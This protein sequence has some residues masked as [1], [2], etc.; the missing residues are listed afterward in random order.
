MNYGNAGM[1]IRKATLFCHILVMMTILMMVNPDICA[2][3]VLQAETI[4][5]ETRQVSI[6]TIFAKEQ[7]QTRIR[8][9]YSPEWEVTPFMTFPIGGIVEIFPL[10]MG[11]STTISSVFPYS[12]PAHSLFIWRVGLKAGVS[13]YWARED[14]FSADMFSV[15]V[16][17]E[18]ILE[19]SPLRTFPK[20]KN[21]KATHWE[22]PRP[23]FV[24]YLKFFAGETYLWV[25]R[26]EK[27]G[28]YRG[29]SRSVDSVDFL[30]GA[31]LGFKY[32]LDSRFSLKMEG[33]FFIQTEK[34][35]QSFAAVE[36]GG[37]LHY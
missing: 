10:G 6:N 2:E 32:A 24:P 16:A 26:E 7:K 35:I 31:G 13:Y 17:G 30:G 18:L 29:Y 14:D 20:L 15:P 19:I 36:M 22:K 25:Q 1:G 34:E 3:E 11:F 8:R 33:L 4:N 37:V 27:K 9:T 5:D 21:K 28:Y 12:M 23:V